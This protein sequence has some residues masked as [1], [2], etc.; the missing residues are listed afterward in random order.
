MLYLY[1]KE[2]SQAQEEKVEAN[3]VIR[4]VAG[5]KICE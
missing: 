2:E 4:D 5:L 1:W 3:V